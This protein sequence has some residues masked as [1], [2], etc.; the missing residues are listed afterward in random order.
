MAYFVFERENV[1]ESY[2]CV[3]IVSLKLCEILFV[4][5]LLRSLSSSLL[6]EK[7]RSI[8]SKDE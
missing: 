7:F 3:E 6:R 8:L 4:D 2:A 1:S 5:S